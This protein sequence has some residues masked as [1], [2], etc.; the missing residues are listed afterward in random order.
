MSK[1]QISP[2]HYKYVSIELLLFFKKNKENEIE[3]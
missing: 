1:I 3:M 2:P